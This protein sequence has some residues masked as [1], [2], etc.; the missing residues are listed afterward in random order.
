MPTTLTVPQLVLA[1]LQK[2][3]AVV[4][5]LDAECIAHRGF[6]QA[7]STLSELPKRQNESLLRT[8]LP[9]FGLHFVN[10]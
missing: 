8:A 2:L 1:T 6:L 3:L 9:A 5:I 10:C 7:K 4:A